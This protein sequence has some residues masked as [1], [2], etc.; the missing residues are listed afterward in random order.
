[1]G[2][3]DLLSLSTH[4]LKANYWPLIKSRQT[5]LLTLTGVAGYLCGRPFPMDWLK[6][7]ALLASMLLTIGG[8]T[9]LN[10][11][12]D[13]DIDLK[14][15][16]TRGRPIPSGLVNPGPAAVFGGAL[17]LAGLLIALSLSSL[18]FWLALAG[19]V[20]DLLVYTLW[21]KRRSPWSILW[22]GIAGGIPILAGRCLA[23]GRIDLTG[24]LLGLAI[25]FWIPS[26]NLT[27]GMLHSQDYRQAG[28]PTFLNAYGLPATRALVACSNLATLL[29][30]GGAFARLTVSWPVQVFLGISSLGLVAVVIV[31]WAWS[32][33][34]AVRV[35][36]KYSSVYLLAAMLLLASA[37]FS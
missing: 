30:M 19:I 18:F 13:R 9:S 25:I 37:A 4:R 21:L 31:A 27:L 35:V 28:L 7:A 36:Y 5:F 16:R 22:G 23:I 26:H 34:R 11:V 33:R 1:M 3:R 8:C 32:S 2:T 17:I 12:C 14:M 10:M 29:L 24:L 6:I 20:V 15:E